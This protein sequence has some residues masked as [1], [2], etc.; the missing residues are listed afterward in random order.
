MSEE[1]RGWLGE[2]E[3]ER[4]ES[5]VIGKLEPQDKSTNFHFLVFLGFFFLP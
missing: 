5:S 4:E 1:A 3:S 2:G